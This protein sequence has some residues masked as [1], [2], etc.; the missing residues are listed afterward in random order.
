MCIV[1]ESFHVSVFDDRIVYLKF[2]REPCFS[3]LMKLANDSN[4]REVVLLDVIY[5]ILGASVFDLADRI[6]YGQWLALLSK[7]FSQAAL[8][9][10]CC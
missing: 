1:V 4:E 7:I 10:S 3:I 8:Q 5:R 2:S 9:V 6:D